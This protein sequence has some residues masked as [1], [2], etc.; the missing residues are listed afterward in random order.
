MEI[1]FVIIRILLFL[2]S[3]HV[4]SKK[5]V[6]ICREVVYH[7]TQKGSLLLTYV[8]VRTHSYQKEMKIE[9]IMA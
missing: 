5:F 8:Q 7:I 6:T 9:I 2:R 3:E 1:G 4:I